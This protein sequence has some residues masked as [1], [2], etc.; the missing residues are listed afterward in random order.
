MEERNQNAHY[1]KGTL[2]GKA[3]SILQGFG[4]GLRNLESCHHNSLKDFEVSLVVL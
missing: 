1:V 3:E 2:W 4:S